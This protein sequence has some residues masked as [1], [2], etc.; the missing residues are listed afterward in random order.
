MP[1]FT[2]GFGNIKSLASKIAVKKGAKLGPQ[3]KH[4]KELI[5]A[6]GALVIVSCTENNNNS[7]VNAGRI[8]SKICVLAAENGLASSALGAAALDPATRER[9]KKYFK[10]NGRPVFFIRLGKQ[11]TPARHAPR[12]PLEYIT[13]SA[14]N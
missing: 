3:A 6:S 4:S 14:A 8:F 13:S 9:V 12:Y 1:G 11:K 7:F 10:I 2:H 5:L